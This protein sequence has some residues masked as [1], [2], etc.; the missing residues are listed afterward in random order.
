MVRPNK[1]K[2]GRPCVGERHA[3]RSIIRSIERRHRRLS[4]GGG[5]AVGRWASFG[6]GGGVSSRMPNARQHNKQRRTPSRFRARLQRRLF[7][8]GA[9]W[10]WKDDGSGTKRERTQPQPMLFGRGVGESIHPLVDPSMV[11]GP[12]GCRLLV[13]EATL[14]TALLLSS[15]SSARERYYGGQ[16]RKHST[17]TP[18]ATPSSSRQAIRASIGVEGRPSTICSFNRA[19]PTG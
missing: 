13:V 10:K 6:L 14:P 2:H 17:P 12:V 4:T 1:H 8:A 3:A 9:A 18:A 7:G 11:W 16:A 19:R 15:L 5:R